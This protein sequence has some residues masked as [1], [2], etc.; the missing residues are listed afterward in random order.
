MWRLGQIHAL[1]G[2]GGMAVGTSFLLIFMYV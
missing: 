2:E 1:T